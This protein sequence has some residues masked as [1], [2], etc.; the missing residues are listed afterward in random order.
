[1]NLLTER[2]PSTPVSN[3]K[4]NKTH[5]KSFLQK[6]KQIT[7]TNTNVHK[8]WRIWCWESG[9]RRFPKSG[10][11]GDV[12]HRQSSRMR[13]P[14]FVFRCAASAQSNMAT[15]LICGRLSAGLRNSGSRTTLS[16]AAKVSFVYMYYVTISDHHLWRL[17]HFWSFIMTP[18]SRF[19][20]DISLQANS[21]SLLL[22]L[23]LACQII[24]NSVYSLGGPQMIF[25]GSWWLFCSV[26]LSSCK[27]S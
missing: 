20:F 3:C 15:S 6:G 17:S 12:R 19:R 24:L 2:M 27:S 25:S 14:S 11:A 18:K 13:V 7:V 16:S 23:T 10:C 21:L 22:M 4:H 26:F 5:I 1:M 8:K 9:Q